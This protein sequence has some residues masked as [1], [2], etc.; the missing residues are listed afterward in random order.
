MNED[1]AEGEEEVTEGET[2]ERAGENEF[3]EGDPIE[4]GVDDA[5]LTGSQTTVISQCPVENGAIRTTWGAISGGP[6]I[7]G[8]A[9]EH[10]HQFCVRIFCLSSKINLSFQP[11]SINKIFR[12]KL[13][14]PYLEYEVNKMPDKVNRQQSTTGGRQLCL[15]IWLKL[16]FYKALCYR[17]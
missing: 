16:L 6:V 2:P 5:T 10:K 11:A 1:Y 13:C 17:K 14:W 15:V 8:I 12:Y 4:Q 9:G 7:S 3:D